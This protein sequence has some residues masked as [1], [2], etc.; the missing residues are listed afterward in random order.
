MSDTRARA[1]RWPTAIAAAA[2]LAILGFN[3]AAAPIA[4]PI[5]ERQPSPPTKWI[6]R[7][8]S[9]GTAVDRPG[10]LSR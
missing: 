4:Q 2:I 9:A 7:L 10:W 5:S 3:P 8:V 1:L 6:R